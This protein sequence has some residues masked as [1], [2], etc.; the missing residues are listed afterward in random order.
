MPE[1]GTDYGG[2]R[3]AVGCGGGGV[4]LCCLGVGLGFGAARFGGNWGFGDSAWGM[5]ELRCTEWGFCG[6][7]GLMI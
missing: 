6:E 5:G 7:L 4:V 2:V 1:G 3:L